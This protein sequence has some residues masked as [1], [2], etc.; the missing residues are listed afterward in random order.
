MEKKHLLSKPLKLLK[1]ERWRPYVRY[2][3]KTDTFIAKA[4]KENGTR[5][6]R[7][8]KA[9]HK[10]PSKIKVIMDRKELDIVARI[11]AYLYHD[12]IDDYKEIASDLRK[13]HI[14]KDLRSIDQW[15]NIQ[16]DRLKTQEKKDEKFNLLTQEILDE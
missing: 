4:I 12:K 3:K 2:E 5:R 15:L 7:G 10:I 13:E 8:D 14:Y 16:Y 6:E 9:M 1:N 11:V